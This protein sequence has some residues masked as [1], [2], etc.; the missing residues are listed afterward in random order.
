MSGCTG[1]AVRALD[2]SDDRLESILLALSDDERWQGF[3][4]AANTCCGYTI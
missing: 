1:Q 2:F 4:A 3:E